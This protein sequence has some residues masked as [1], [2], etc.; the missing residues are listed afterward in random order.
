MHS[1]KEQKFAVVYVA[2]DRSEVL[3]VFAL[4]CKEA[5]VAYAKQ[6]A[7]NYARSLVC[8]FGLF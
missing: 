1:G 8:R 5:A 4:E 2:G 6:T 7:K 3:K